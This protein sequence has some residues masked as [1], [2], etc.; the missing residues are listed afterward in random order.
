MFRN[1]GVPPKQ[2][3]TTFS[4]SDNA[5]IKPGIYTYITFKEILTRCTLCIQWTLTSDAGQ[6]NKFLMY[7]CLFYVQALL[8][9][10]HISVQANMWTSQ[11]NR[12]FWSA[13]FFAPHWHSLF[14]ASVSTSCPCS[15]PALTF[16]SI[17]SLYISLSSD[18]IQLPSLNLVVCTYIF[19][20][21]FSLCV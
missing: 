3:V 10:Q 9:M 8:C 11:A 16:W 7:S 6:K 2:K 18:I 20:I 5:L 15:S 13:N 12:K 1:A 21:L 17:F 19:F 4:V 14:L